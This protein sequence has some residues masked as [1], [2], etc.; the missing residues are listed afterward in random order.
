[1]YIVIFLYSSENLAVHKT[2]SFR[3]FMILFSFALVVARE[4][5]HGVLVVDNTV[6][7]EQ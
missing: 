2:T 7:Y 1:M 3:R 5:D 4:N 6:I